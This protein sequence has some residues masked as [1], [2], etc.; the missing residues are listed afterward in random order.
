MIY[1]NLKELNQQLPNKGRLMSLDIG[2]KT[3]GV[4]ICD[5]NWLI[6]NPK[7]TIARF[8]GKKDFLAIIKIIKENQIV[9]III[10][11]PLNMDGSVSKMSEFVRKFAN[12]LDDFLSTNQIEN[13]IAFFD[14]R[15]SSF[16]AEEIMQDSKVRNNKRKQLI[17]QIAASVILQ[18]ALDEMNL[19][20]NI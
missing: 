14:E 3:I 18:G 9:A 13:K 5:G 1:N 19:I 20:K 12:N 8:G 4:A 2:T 17:D 6:A 11:L 15:L 16:E 7:L 10:G